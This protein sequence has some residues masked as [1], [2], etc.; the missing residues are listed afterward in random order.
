MKNYRDCSE[1]CVSNLQL[2][3]LYHSVAFTTYL[4]K[5]PKNTGC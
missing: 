5:I 4:E 1:F 2:L 3:K